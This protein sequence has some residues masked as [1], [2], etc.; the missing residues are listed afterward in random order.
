[1]EARIENS[2]LFL[3]IFFRAAMGGFHQN[4][5]LTGITEQPYGLSSHDAI[6]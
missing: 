5:P 1:M 6:G 4:L 2:A 3:K